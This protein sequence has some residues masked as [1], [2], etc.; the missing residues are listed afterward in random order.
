MNILIAYASRHGTTKT[1]AERLRDLLRGVEVTLCDVTTQMPDIS[2]FDLII[3][4]SS[5]RFGKLHP[6]YQT[7]LKKNEQIL[8]KKPFG[9]FLCCGLAHEYEYYE[10]TLLSK[11]LRDNAFQ[12][13]YFGGTLKTEGARLWEKMVIRSMRSSLL[14]SEIADGEYTPSLPGILPENIER[15]AT[16]ARKKI[17]RI[18][19]TRRTTNQSFES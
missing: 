15:M 12:V 9:L 10:E 7:F 8:L 13:L 3:A 19:T 1:C 17:E 6:A 16:Y 11:Q 14:E 2:E 4:G 18:K 5:V